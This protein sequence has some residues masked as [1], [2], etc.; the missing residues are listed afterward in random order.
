MLIKTRKLPATSTDGERMRA[1]A[2]NGAT[3][4][5]PFPYRDYS[6]GLMSPNTRVAQ[7]LALALGAGV[8]S[9]WDNVKHIPGSLNYEWNG[10]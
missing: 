10:E 5:V 8:D 3:L 7:A 2:E 6:S 9:V 4:T 1:T